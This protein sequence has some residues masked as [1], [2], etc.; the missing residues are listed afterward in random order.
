[1]PCHTL[2]S[3]CE[4]VDKRQRL[5][6][7]IDNVDIVIGNHHT[8]NQT[9]LADRV[10][11]FDEFNPEPFLQ[12]FP[13]DTDYSVADSPAELVS[14]FVAAVDAIPLESFTDVIEA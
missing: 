12:R 5:I 14:E 11:I 6:D 4:Y 1:M 8:Y 7:E 10:V 3:P 13:S 9:Y 2:D